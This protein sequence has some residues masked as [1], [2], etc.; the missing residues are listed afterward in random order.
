MSHTRSHRSWTNRNR[1]RKKRALCP[2]GAPTFQTKDPTMHPKLDEIA[3]QLSRNTNHIAEIRTAL[4]AAT[5]RINEVAI[6]LQHTPN[7]DQLTTYRAAL[8]HLDACLLRLKD[9]VDLIA[10]RL[11]NVP[12]KMREPKPLQK[13]TRNDNDTL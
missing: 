13:G 1:D 9:R 7:I 8:D 3:Y 11:P 4:T 10:D 12:I 5:D 2:S 6:H